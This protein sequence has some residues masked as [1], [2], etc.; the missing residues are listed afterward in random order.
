MNA[1]SNVAIPPHLRD[2][3]RERILITPEGIALP[4]TVASRGA[5]LG[6]L[7][8]DLTFVSVLM[9]ITTL[10]LIWIA[11]GAANLFNE[12]QGDAAFSALEFLAVVWIIAMFLFRNA[13]FLFFELGAR[14]ATPGKRL[15]GIRVAARDGGRLTVEM[16]VARNLLRDIELFLPFVFLAGAVS[17]D[18]GTPAGLAAL[19][20]FLVFALFPFFNRDRMRAGD[21]IAGTWVVE[22][23][24]QK[25]VEA[26][27]GTETTTA[28]ASASQPELATGGA[29]L[30]A[31]VF[32]AEEL[33][34]YGEYELQTLERVLRDDRSEALEKVQ[35]TIAHKIGRDPWDPDPRSFLQAYYKQLRA[36][37]EGQMRMGQRK[38]DKFAD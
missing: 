2:A 33:S 7:L 16:V 5:R 29:R 15:T 1:L 27:S 13:W 10:G 30:P 38:I 31:Y 37:L 14:G 20:W 11:G 3:G 21:L 6:A 4:L 9:I 36:R 18:D 28:T 22:A 25:L 17:S 8:L 35:Q 34:V 26:M 23:P 32:S 12:A 24:R 19:A